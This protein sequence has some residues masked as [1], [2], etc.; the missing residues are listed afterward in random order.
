MPPKKET[1]RRKK[2]HDDPLS[3]PKKSHFSINELASL[4][5][6]DKHSDLYW[7][8][9]AAKGRSGF[10]QQLLDEKN[11]DAARLSPERIAQAKAAASSN[12]KTKTFSRSAFSSAQ[13]KMSESEQSEYYQKVYPFNYL[14]LEDFSNTADSI[15]R[16][17]K[18]EQTTGASTNDAKSRSMEAIVLYSRFLQDETPLDL[19]KCVYVDL[20][21]NGG[22]TALYGSAFDYRKILSVE[23]T[24]AGREEAKNRVKTIPGLNE[25]CSLVVGTYRDYFPYDAQ[26]YY[27]DCTW[28]CDG[29]TFVDES[30][31][32][33]DVFHL[34][35][36]IEQQ[37]NPA[38]ICLLTQTKDLDVVRDF[39]VRHMKCLLRT[40]IHFGMPDE[41]VTWVFEVIPHRDEK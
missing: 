37:P 39:G 20:M 36:K 40:I 18:I 29:R 1:V 12:T 26:V 41:C 31:F 23:L 32:I 17:Y 3:P 14:T 2:L 28:V 24:E 16:V 25:K 10:V 33:R 11:A 21:S 4:N 13:P 34:C 6:E 7:N 35:S 15:E 9:P 19:T 30:V 5:P 22:E 27:M 8:S 38:Y